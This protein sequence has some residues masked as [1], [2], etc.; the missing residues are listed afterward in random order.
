M[1]QTSVYKIKLSTLT[2]VAIGSGEELWPY[3]DYIEE[4]GHI[5]VIDK[6]ALQEK[7]ATNDHW[8][9]LYVEGV[10]KGMDN[11]RSSFD[12]KKFIVHTL[13]ETVQ[14]LSIAKY[15]L[16]TKIANQKIPVRSILKSP[17][18][19]PYIPG[20][21]LK[22]AMNSAIM[23]SWLNNINEEED[24]RAAL[25]WVEDLSKL[26]GIKNKS[27]WRSIEKHLELLKEQAIEQKKLK[28]RVADSAPMDRKI[29]VVDC[30]RSMN[31]R[32]ECIA[33]N[34]VSELEIELAGITWEELMFAINL[35]SYNMLCRTM[36]ILCAKENDKE[37]RLFL[38]NLERL[39]KELDS[40]A[41]NRQ[42]DTAYLRLGFGKGFYFNSVFLAIYNWMQGNEVGKKFQQ[43]FMK[44]YPKMK[45]LDTFPETYIKTN[46]SNEPLGW[47]KIEKQKTI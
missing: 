28:I 24:N 9:D 19:E 4:A 5:Y 39:E 27:E 26:I 32:L 41:D 30:Y 11:N 35:Y 12:L 7:L 45:N 40:L 18:G 6:V 21:S 46:C 8:M 37:D 17:F 20:S 16:E 22:G 13:N 38:A 1:N 29:A 2:P 47:V 23:Y 36:E 10:A 25:E 15:P 42:A 44:K 33:S 14:S 3:A 34:V 31:L 43:F